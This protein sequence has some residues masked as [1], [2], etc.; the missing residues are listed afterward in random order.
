M[1]GGEGHSPWHT[2]TSA[3]GGEVVM[4]GGVDVVVGSGGGREGGACHRRRCGGPTWKWVT[5]VGVEEEVEIARGWGAERERERSDR[6]RG[7]LDPWK[8]PGLVRTAEA[9]GSRT[10]GIKGAC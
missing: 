6:E 5:E 1:H 8:V 4:T 10:A 9:S 7:V 2:L 3:G